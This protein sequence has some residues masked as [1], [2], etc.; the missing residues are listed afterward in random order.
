MKI[1]NEYRIRR[2]KLNHTVEKK[3]DNGKW[4]AVAFFSRF[5]SGLGSCVN[6]LM[7]KGV[8][9]SDSQCQE[10]RAMADKEPKTQP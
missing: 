9:I 6:F 1:N 4:A 5:E 7:E 10:L 8:D 2:D 3:S